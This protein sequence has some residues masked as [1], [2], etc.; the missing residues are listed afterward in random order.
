MP[1]ITGE[2]GADLLSGGQDAD[3]I[4]GRGGGDTLI[5]REGDD[6][7]QGGAGDD[8]IGGDNI[9]RPGGPFQPSDFGPF[10]R[11][12]PIGP[13]DNLLLAGG[14][15]DR[16]F[17]GFGADTVFGGAGDDTINGYGVS[18]V[19]PV[20]SGNLIA[21]DG[22]DRLFGGAGDDLV[23]GGGGDDLLS[24]GRGADTLVGGVGIDTFIGGAG[25]DRF[26]FGRN[27]EPDGTSYIADTG[28]GPGQRDVILDFREGLDQLDLSAYR[29]SFPPPGGQPAPVF[30]GTAEFGE[31]AA[32]QVRFEV[33]GCTTLVQFLSPL[34]DASQPPPPLQ[35]IELAGRHWL[36][37]GDVIL[38]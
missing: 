28:A 19:S 1:V 23:R 32:L 5:G 14:G 33:V 21:A 7:V 27:L 13:G 15:G 37:A 3:L 29:N 22:P 38:R 10:P 34:G 35:E 9:P 18:N 26:V 25:A 20:G 24:G 36:D 4:L 2:T 8:L 30:L 11:A 17:A 6:V 12:R 31:S 16:V